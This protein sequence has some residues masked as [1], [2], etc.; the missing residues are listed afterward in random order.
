M[1]VRVR[2]N[3]CATAGYAGGVTVCRVWRTRI[4]PREADAYRRFA[5]DESLPMFR[6]HDGFLGVVFGEAAAERVVI[7]FWRSAEAV[8]ELDASPRYHRTV[9]RIESTGFIVGPSSVDVF[10][11]GG[12]AIDAPLF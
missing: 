1:I 12:G 5:A 6:S 11:V 7:T 10:E 9:E 4:D 2:P 8:E 3:D